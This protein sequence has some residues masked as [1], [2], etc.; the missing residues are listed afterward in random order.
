MEKK[1]VDFFEDGRIDNLGILALEG[2][3][4]HQIGVAHRTIDD[5]RHP[6]RIKTLVE[7]S[8]NGTTREIVGEVKHFH[9]LYY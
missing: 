4:S 9:L 3:S 7:F 6:L 1:S 8:V 2:I 5:L